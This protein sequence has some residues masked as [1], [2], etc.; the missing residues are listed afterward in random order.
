MW[1]F[2]IRKDVFKNLTFELVKVVN[3][4]QMSIMAKIT[5]RCEHEPERISEQSM[6]VKDEK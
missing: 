1:N 5:L 4:I 3:L 2:G 6:L